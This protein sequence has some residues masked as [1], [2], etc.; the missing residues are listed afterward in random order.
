[1]NFY[2]FHRNSPSGEKLSSDWHVGEG[3]EDIT[4]ID[5]T[6]YHHVDVICK[7]DKIKS[8]SPV[9]VDNKLGTNDLFFLNAKLWKYH[10]YSPPSELNARAAPS[11]DG[12]PSL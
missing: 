3:I 4:V 7:V 6:N 10:V 11:P 1:L 12:F 9:D 5:N 2:P 8:Q